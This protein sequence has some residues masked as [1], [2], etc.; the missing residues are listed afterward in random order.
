MM[1][2]YQDLWRPQD[3][4]LEL[5][6][7]QGLRCCAVLPKS[8]INIKSLGVIILYLFFK[9]VDIFHTYL[10]N[11]VKSPSHRNQHH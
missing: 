10:R 6:Y 3:L 7:Q 4:V 8:E 2:N 11:S 1:S 9:V 5:L